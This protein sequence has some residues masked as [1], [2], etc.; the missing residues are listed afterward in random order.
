MHR[1]Y[2]PD[3]D[4][5]AQLVELPPDEAFHLR[6]VLRLGEGT[7]IEV[8]DGRG[9]QWTAA[10][11][12][13]SR[14]AVVVR[15]EERIPARPDPTVPIVI[16]PALLKGDKLDEVIRHATAL[17]VVAVRPLIAA[18][19][20]VRADRLKR[21]TRVQRWQRLAIA[22]AKQSGRAWIPTVHP[23]APFEEIIAGGL[24]AQPP[25]FPGSVGEPGRGDALPIL[26]CEPTAGGQ[27][28][29]AL[30]RRIPAPPRTV[31]I[32]V[33]PEG[34]W[35]AGELARAAAAGFE[36]VTLGSLILRA[37]L[38]P[39]VAVTLFRFAWAADQT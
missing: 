26:L 29:T 33:G 25:S 14:R 3:V 22:A 6:S 35:T 38:A 27:D 4:P 20:E 8:F 34:G 31:T 2:A 17:G 19:S 30:L 9:H 7:A 12:S 1:F 16:A 5:A 37:E 18:R 39:I 24:E 28:V 32:V 13:V 11:A 15:L 23:P 21:Q 10:V 36:R